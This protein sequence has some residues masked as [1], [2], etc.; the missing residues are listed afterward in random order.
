ML[1]TSK[2]FSVSK[3]ESAIIV[4][5]KFYIFKSFIVYLNGRMNYLRAGGNDKGV[6][7]LTQWS[8]M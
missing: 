1:R 7:G 8:R 3:M 6:M 2:M 5:F 4:H